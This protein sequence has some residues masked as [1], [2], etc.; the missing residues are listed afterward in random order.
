VAGARKYA[1]QKARINSPMQ[2]KLRILAMLADITAMPVNSKI[3]ATR[4]II[5]KILARTNMGLLLLREYG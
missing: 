3:A 4:A 2:I 1:E 5:R